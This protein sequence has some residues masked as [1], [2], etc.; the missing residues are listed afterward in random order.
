MQTDGEQEPGAVS[1][2]ILGRLRRID[3]QLALLSEEL[4]LPAGESAAAERDRGLRGGGDVDADEPA[5]AR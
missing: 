3:A 4:G 1:E 5:S 2:R